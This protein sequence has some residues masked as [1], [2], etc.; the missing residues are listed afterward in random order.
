MITRSQFPSSSLGYWRGTP[1]LAGPD[2]GGYPMAAQ[3]TAGM[4]QGT[5]AVRIAGAQWHPSVIYLLGLV[6]VELVVFKY[7]EQALR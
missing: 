7:I 4:S 2:A 5:G 6:V 1:G 3:G